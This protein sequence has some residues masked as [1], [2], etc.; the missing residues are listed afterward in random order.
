MHIYIWNMLICLYALVCVYMIVGLTILHWITSKKMHPKMRLILLSAVTSSLSR[1]E[2]LWNFPMAILTFLLILPLVWSCLCLSKK[3]C[4]IID[5]QIFWLLTIF[6]LFLTKF[7]DPWCPEWHLLGQGSLQ[8]VD[9]YTRKYGA[10]CQWG[11]HIQTVL[12]SCSTHKPW[13]LLAWQDMQ[14]TAA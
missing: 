9:L 2:V 4:F 5:F 7:P 11:G 3:G 1:R 12:L 14:P 10:N 8:P 13:Q 6:R